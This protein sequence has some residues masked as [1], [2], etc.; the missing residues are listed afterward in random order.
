MRLL[1]YSPAF[2]PSLGGLE[3]HVAHLAEE[4]QALG[5]DVVVVTQ[6]AAACGSE[7]P[8]PYRVVRQPTRREL[9]RWARWCDVFHQANVSLRG[10]W[11]L[12]LVRRPW[13]VSHHSW[14]CRTDGWIALA[15]RLKRH[16]VRYAAASIAVSRAVADDLGGA[17]VVPNTFRDQLFRRL[18]EV[19]RDHDLLFVGRLVSD[20]GADVLLAALGRLAEQGIR[21]RLTIVGGGPE[22]QRLE[23]QASELGI[24]EQATF[25]GAR[26]DHELVETMNRHRILVVPS[27]YHEPFGIVALE[28]IACGCV[29]VGS[30]GGGL[31]EAIG[32]CGLTFENGHDA[33]LAAALAEA[34]QWSD[35]QRESLLAASA[36]H[37]EAHSSSRIM[38]RYAEL[39]EAAAGDHGK[40]GRLATV[41]KP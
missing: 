27:R 2:L 40:R 12:L 6:T 4:M 20:K 11:P 36:G 22:R 31:P 3:L 15:D 39:L 35:S 28:G 30:R 34:L 37:L 14:Y 18:S 26:R 32:P 7:E 16:L 17:T 21:P 9:L 33:G 25:L 38:A 19:P 5:H 24:A 13:V 29:I 41:A 10:L 8:T 23:E 1:I